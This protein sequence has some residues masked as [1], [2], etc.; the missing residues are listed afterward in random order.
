MKLLVS[1]L[2]GLVSTALLLTV[3]GWLNTTPEKQ[4]N[5]RIAT[6]D[7]SVPQEK[8]RPT[9]PPP[10][11]TPPRPPRTNER[12]LAPAPGATSGLSNLAIEVPDYTSS[13]LDE[14]GSG[15]LGQVGDVAMTSDTVDRPPT[16]RQGALTYPERAKQRGQEGL[17]TVSL[18]IN[19]EGRVDKLKILEAV[20]PGVFDQAVL[21]GVPG[22]VFAPAEYQGRPVPVWVTLPL[23]FKLK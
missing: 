14:G 9:P 17:V 19:A 20:P 7:F 21:E 16:V 13:N 5:E 10:P 18:L 4:N 12:T 15:L 6:V 23:E 3:I 11:T 8:P 1:L 2:A 22:W